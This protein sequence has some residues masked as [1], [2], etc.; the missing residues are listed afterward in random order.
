MKANYDITGMNC[1]ACSAAVERAVRSLGVN[2]VSVNLLSGTMKVDFDE[3]S[4]TDSAIR[5]A[6]IK[7]GFGIDTAKSS[8][9][10]RKI[11]RETAIKNE[12]NL[13]HR[14]ISSVVIMSLLMYFSMGHM[15]GL[16]LPS[17]LSSPETLS[18]IQLLLTIPILI[19]N[20]TYFLGGFRHLFART[21]N[22]DSLISL[23]AR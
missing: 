13:L 20:R 8:F 6:V 15:F 18:L 23:S 9:E 19:I 5:T 7:A 14:L 10:K 2:E 3:V 21:P 17:F 16:P 11:L 22:M 4:V 12:R 1:A